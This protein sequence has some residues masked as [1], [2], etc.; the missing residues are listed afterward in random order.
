MLAFCSTVVVPIQK[1]HAVAPLVAAGG[2]EAGALMFW[3][4]A[5]LIA[6]AGAAVGMDPDVSQS[7]EDFGKSAW[8]GANDAVKTSLTSSFSAMSDAWNTTSK[9]AV[10]IGSEARMYLEGKWDDWF[11]GGMVMDANGQIT[12]VASLNEMILP[13]KYYANLDQFCGNECLNLGLLVGWQSWGG[14]ESI[15][16]D[17]NGRG[18]MYFQDSSNTKVIYRAEGFANALAMFEYAKVTWGIV[19]NGLTIDQ[20]IFEKTNTSG[21][22]VGQYTPLVFPQTFPDTMVL[23]APQGTLNPDNT[24]EDYRT[25]VI[26]RVGNVAEGDI[27]VGYG[28]ITAAD[29][30]VAT[31]VDPS[32]T[33]TWETPTDTA[34]IDWSPLLLAGTDFTTK[35]PFS[36]PWDLKRQMDVFNVEPEAPVIHFDDTIPIFGGI[37]IDFD[38][39]FAPFDF[40]ATAA[41]WFLV[42]VFDIS[43]I[44]GLRRLMSE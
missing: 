15:K 24:V 33:P 34:K 21:A 12:S 7:I 1:A 38:I 41:R 3:G 19:P 14:I 13:S 37:P 35:F 8:V 27:A 39:D 30:I 32:A 43:I 11:G 16:A 42:I 4:G 9:F 36:I 5:V 10:T 17:V 26:G 25:P 22:V 40:M 6:S 23:P 20:G 29:T 44:L 18:V 31:P 2:I 28:S